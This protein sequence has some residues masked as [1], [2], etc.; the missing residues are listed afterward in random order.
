MLGF[1]KSIA[2]IF[3]GGVSAIWHWVINLFNGVWSYIY[4]M[5]DVLVHDISEGFSYAKNLFDYLSTWVVHTVDNVVNLIKK[6]EGDIQHWAIGLVNKVASYAEDVY[7]WAIQQ[8]D[9]LAHAIDKAYDDIEQWVIFKV[10]NPL[11]NFIKSALNWINN[12]GAQMWDL[13]T[14]P[15]KLVSLLESYLFSAWLTWLQRLAVPITGYILRNM[16]RFAP[17]LVSLAE[18]II[19]KVL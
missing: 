8:L 3:T 5:W 1:L 13:L 7:H 16:I 17:D 2:N 9:N 10:W 18:D 19:T 14:H 11:W 4:H 12:E 15:E 6:V